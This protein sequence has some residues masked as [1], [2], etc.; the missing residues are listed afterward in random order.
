MFKTRHTIGAKG[1]PFPQVQSHCALQYQKFPVNL[2]K[3]E[4][5]KD[6]ENGF[7]PKLV[8]D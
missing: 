6:F 2:K 1:I 4:S 7:D 5:G 8:Q 3:I